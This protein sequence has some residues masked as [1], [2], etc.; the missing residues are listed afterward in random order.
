VIGQR[1]VEDES[2]KYVAADAD[3][4]RDDGNLT[5]SNPV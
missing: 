2:D 3:Q 4:G 1:E 5:R